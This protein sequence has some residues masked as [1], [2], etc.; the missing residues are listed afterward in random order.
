LVILTIFKVTFVFDIKL[1]ILELAIF[2]KLRLESVT[3]N[4]F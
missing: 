1:S 4:Y 3:Y 2:S